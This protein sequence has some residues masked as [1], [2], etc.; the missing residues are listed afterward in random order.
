MVSDRETARILGGTPGPPGTFLKVV[1]DAATGQYLVLGSRDRAVAALI[2]QGLTGQGVSTAI[3]DTGLWLEHPAIRQA[4][5]DTADMTGEGPNDLNG[6]GTEVA[7]VALATAPDQLLY[8]AKALNRDGEGTRETLIAGISW[9]FETG[10]NMINLSAGVYDNECAGNCALCEMAREAAQRKMLLLA[11]AGNH[12]DVTA[13]PAKYF[14]AHPRE[15]VAVAAFDVDEGVIAASSGIGT[16]L[17][18]VGT[19]ELRPWDDTRR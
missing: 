19:Y 1:F 7:L 9:A 11:A 8:S 2:Q 12:R 17:G 10:A 16:L 4:V 3:V 15:G 5:V 14:V 13:C 6:H 18:D